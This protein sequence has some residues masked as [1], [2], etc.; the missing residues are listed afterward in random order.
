MVL[1][2]NPKDWNSGYAGFAENLRKFDHRDR[3]ENRVVRSREKSRL[4]AANDRNS[5]GAQFLD[6]GRISAPFLLLCSQGGAQRFTMRGTERRTLPRK[7]NDRV[8]RIV[9]RIEIPDAFPVVDVIK[10]ERRHRRQA[11]EGNTHHESSANSLFILRKICDKSS[12]SAGFRGSS[13]RLGTPASNPSRSIAALSPAMPYFSVTAP[14]AG[15]MM[16][17]T[18]PAF[19]DSPAAKARYSASACLGAAH[20][21]ATIPP[22]PPSPIPRNTLRA[23]PSTT[24]NFPP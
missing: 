9:S 6:K 7:G 2:S 10:E 15:A 19:L 3:F 5:A 13:G 11:S 17:W 14:A 21:R 18:D 24:G 4:L 23:H 20:A 16:R 8:Y 22:L 12:R 1:R